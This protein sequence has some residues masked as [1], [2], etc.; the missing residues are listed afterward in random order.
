MKKFLVTSVLTLL[1]ATPVL[2]ANELTFDADTTINL[3]DLS[4][5]LIIKSGS[6]V[7]SMT[8]NSGSITFVV[9]SG[10]SFTIESSDQRAMALS[11]ALAGQSFTCANP[12]K[13]IFTPQT[14]ISGTS[15]TL[16]PSATVC[17][18]GGG[19]ASTGGGGGGG[20]SSSS[21]S[22]TVTEPETTAKTTTESPATAETPA[23][24]T[25]TAAEKAAEQVKNIV[26]EAATIAGRS[27]ESVLA[28]VGA[29]QDAKAEA[30]TEIKYTNKLVSDLKNNVTAEERIAI[31]NFINY[32]TPTTKILGA[33]ERAGVI[34]SYKSAFGKVPTTATEWSDTIKIGNGR[35]PSETNA[36]AETKAAAEF[37][38]VYKRSADMKQANDNAAV[39]VISYGLRPTARNLNSEKA[40]IKSF[41]AVYGHNP[42]SALAWD[43]VRAIAY[44]GAKR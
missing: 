28:A 38:K 36:A 21:S 13:L 12:S 25:N 43:I 37:K 4:I 40:A 8:A 2:A 31:T 42:V 19:S 27:V 29:M 30:A 17:S 32:G 41:K 22:T 3:P 24:T 11:P 10:N 35:W 23:T 39:T 16:T 7:D 33:G 15:V 6:V 34:S 26:A 14:G 44:S 5:N 1:L 9:S 20:G 18:S